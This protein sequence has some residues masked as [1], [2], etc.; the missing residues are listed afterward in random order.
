MSKQKPNTNP[1]A[2]NT[3]K[4]HAKQSAIPQ[5]A[6]PLDTK[7]RILDEALS[8]FAQKGYANVFVGE[9]AEKVG[10]KAPSL[11]KHFK[12]KQ[13]IFEGVLEE[14]NERYRA[15]TSLMNFGGENAQ[16]DAPFFQNITEDKLVEVGTMLFQYFLHDEYSSRFRKM[17]TIEQFNN[18]EL[19][20]L[21]DKIYVDEPLSYQ[22][23]VLGML[24]QQG[25]LKTDKVDIM[26]LQFYAPI[27]LLLSICD[28]DS[29]R[30]EEALKTLAEHIRQ[31]NKIYGRKK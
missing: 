30:E 27:F 19:A 8:L 14:M 4:P 7:H 21:Y 17:M 15:Q 20:R 11:Y 31:F 22:G 28:R 1:S 24:T 26:T 10:I 13:A 9:I 5:P 23:A 6:A 18:P 12:S 2:T 29:K 16:D 3:A 25:L